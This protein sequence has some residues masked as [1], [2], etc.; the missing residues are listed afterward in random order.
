MR[1]VRTLTSDAEMLFKIIAFFAMAHS[2][3]REV[4]VVTSVFAIK[5]ALQSIVQSPYNVQK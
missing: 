1:A 3:F 2:L 5:I 4:V